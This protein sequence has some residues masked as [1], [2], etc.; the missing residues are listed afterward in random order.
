MNLR[1][2][3][4]LGIKIGDF[5]IAYYGVLIIA[6]VTAG[7]FLAG[8]LTKKFHLIFDNF[9]L[10]AAFGGLGG[11]IGAKLLYLLVSWNKIDFSRLMELSYV[12]ELMRGGFVF[13]GG[14]AGG[15]LGLMICKKLCGISVWKYAEIYI[16]CLPLVHAFGRMG[17]TLTGCCYGIPYD[18]IGAIVYHHSIIAPNNITLFPVQVVE[19]G[20][21]LLIVV[22]LLVY[23][24]K[25]RKSH[26]NSIILYCTLYAAVRFILEFLRYDLDRGQ[27]LWFSTSQWISLAVIGIVAIYGF[28]KKGVTYE[29]Q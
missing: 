19:A 27:F 21:D 9:I 17:C 6:G 29:G 12:S 22:I 3:I 4:V 7:I 1:R 23:I 2:G 10:T 24:F 20:A 11:M 13:Y 8:I 26:Q 14:L 5:F 15:V 16:P 28:G 18:G 25:K